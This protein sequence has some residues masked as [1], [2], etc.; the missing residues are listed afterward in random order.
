MPL[1]MV[2]MDGAVLPVSAHASEQA[3]WG[4]PSLDGHRSLSKSTSC[5]WTFPSFLGPKDR[6][7]S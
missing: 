2:K 3:G 6:I 7:P 4:L 5:T 1:R